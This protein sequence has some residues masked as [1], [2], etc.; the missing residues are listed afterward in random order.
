VVFNYQSIEV[1]FENLIRDDAEENPTV[2]NRQAF[3][4]LISLF[5]ELVRHDVFSHDIYVCMLISRGDLQSS[6]SWSAYMQVTSV[7]PDHSELSSVKSEG[8]K[9]EVSRRHTA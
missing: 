6:N 8:V 2:D 9:Q 3:A 4:N 7:N 5:T 1:I